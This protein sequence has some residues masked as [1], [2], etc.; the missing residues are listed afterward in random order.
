MKKGKDIDI[1]IQ[2]RSGKTEIKD[3]LD[4]HLAL[5]SDKVISDLN[6]VLTET[7]SSTKN[8]KLSKLNSITQTY[9]IE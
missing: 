9:R 1:Q 7:R 3:L 2:I 4:L 6:L 5:L 8:N